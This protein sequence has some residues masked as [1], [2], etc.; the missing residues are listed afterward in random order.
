MDV[1]AF[2][3]LSKI[4]KCAFGIFLLSMAFCLKIYCFFLAKRL[5]QSSRLSGQQLLDDI[6]GDTTPNTKVKAKSTLFS[7][8]KS[9][10]ALN[11]KTMSKVKSEPNSVPTPPASIST[12]KPRADN[13]N[14]IKP[15]QGC[16]TLDEKTRLIIEE[17]RQ[18]AI[19]KLRQSKQLGSS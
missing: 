5:S 12:V 3:T 11:S 17:K 10:S 18:A 6:L 1:W 8:N 16:Q 9:D 15:K 2:L 19:K 7:Q 4:M 14:R 13:S